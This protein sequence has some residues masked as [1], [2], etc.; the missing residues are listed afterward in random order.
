MTT[1]KIHFTL[2]LLFLISMF[3]MQTEVNA[4]TG[5]LQVT[6]EANIR[7][8]IDNDFKGVTN[9]SENGLF[10]ENLSPGRH[11]LKAI[12][13]GFDP[14]VK[15]ISI[16]ASK[17]IEVKINFG[18]RQEQIKSL[19]PEEGQTLSQVGNM[20]LRSVPLG[21]KVTINGKS[22]QQKTDFE[23]S[24][25]P[26][27]QHKVSFER[28]N[29]RLA[30]LF[31]LDA[32]ET[33]KLKAHFKEGKIIDLSKIEREEAEKISREEQARRERV[34]RE[35]QARLEQSQREEQER[36]ERV[37]REEQARNAKF[38]L[39]PTGTFM[40]GSSNVHDNNKRRQ[41]TINKSFY[42]QTTEVT[43]WQWRRVMGDIPS[44]YSSC[45]DDC[46]VWWVTWEEAQD[47]I[48][49]LN[50]MEG[51]NSYRLPTA[52]EWEYAARAGTTTVY[53]FGDDAGRLG[54]YAWIGYN[55]GGKH[56]PV[57]Q[58]KPNPWGLYDVHGNSHEWV[59]N[60]FAW[61]NHF[62]RGG[63]HYSDAQSCSSSY[64]NVA[65]PSYNVR[66]AGFRLAREVRP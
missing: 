65:G 51:T 47:F 29:Q 32:N 13:K 10:I 14:F 56:H 61:G 35:E 58:K 26:I 17:A 37:Q 45:G 27:G 43:Q 19:Q 64:S 66:T 38:V 55:S 54:E 39:V 31:N 46:P 59:E 12:K 6:C 40:M 44:K 57:G 2:T 25:F 36:R 24:N 7:I 42:I 8:F 16:I 18:Q 30:G 3:T 63:G 4:A 49:K 21:A 52:E 28:G 5:D 15:D 22:Y 23:I 1:R 33:L 62:I 20:E 50:N 9:D 53:S 60:A 48:Q 11:T 34:Q 41:V